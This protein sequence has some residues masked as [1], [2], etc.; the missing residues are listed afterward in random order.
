MIDKISTGDLLEGAVAYARD[1]VDGGAPCRDSAGMHVDVAALQADFF[2]NLRQSIARK[3]RGFFAPERCIQAIEAACSLPLEQGLERES[4]LF[5][6]C[7][8]TP[9]AR[10]QQHLFFAERAAGHVPGVDPKVAP[11]DV[12]SVGIVGSGTMGGGIAMCFLNAG[13]PVVLLDLDGE[14]LDRGVAVIRKNYD[15]SAKKGRLTQQQVEER[16]NLLGTTTDYAEL[17]EVDMV[18]EAVFEKMEV[19]KDVFAALDTVCKPGCILASNTSTLDINEIAASTGR[20]ADVIGLHFFSPA[21]VM[22]LLEIVRCTE[23]A[24]DVIVTSMRLGKKIGKVPVVV[25]VCFGFVGNRMLEPYTREA[26]RLVL[27]GATPAQIDAALY[28]FGMAMGPLAMSDLA[29]LDIGTFVRQSF[30][31]L[32]GGDAAYAAIA[33]RLVEMG[34]L[35]QKSGRG[36][37]IYEGRDRREDPEVM[38]LA[39]EIAAEHGIRQREFTNEE[40]VERTIYPLINE[41]ARVVADGIAARPSD[42]DLVYANGYGFPWWRGGPMQYADEVGLDAVVDGLIRWR[43]ALGDYG[44]QWFEPAPLMAQLA[45]EGQSFAR[46]AAH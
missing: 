41:G 7:M 44:R 32:T 16:M 4:E 35:G 22:R 3:T 23:T 13:I 40:I 11:R 39:R 29:G 14:A 37:Y 27:E 30:P 28:E 1:L 24:D 17:D 6:E 33:D 21:N 19:K 2:D 12:Q 31:Q 25:G 34:R 42:C 43:D 5:I 45:D 18:I 8:Q 10:A 9:Q 46:G 15:I 26:T 36:F 20:P 38:E